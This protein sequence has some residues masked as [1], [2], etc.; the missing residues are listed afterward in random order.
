M[1]Q[2]IKEEAQRNLVHVES[3]CRSFYVELSKNLGSIVNLTKSK[4]WLQYLWLTNSI[5]RYTRDSDLTMYARKTLVQTTILA[6]STGSH[7]SQ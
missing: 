7:N 1:K 2:I 4:N 6:L 3:T 5:S